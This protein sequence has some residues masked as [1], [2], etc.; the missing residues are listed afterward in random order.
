MSESYNTI[1]WVKRLH[2][3]QSLFLCLPL[4][5]KVAKPQVL[6]DEVQM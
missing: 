5:G 6:T 4:E 2:I 3:V 1:G